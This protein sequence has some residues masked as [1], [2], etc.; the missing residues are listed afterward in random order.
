MPAEQSRILIYLLPALPGFHPTVTSA[1]RLSHFLQEEHSPSSPMLGARSCVHPHQEIHFNDSQ[2][3]LMQSVHFSRPSVLLVFADVGQGCLEWPRA[4]WGA[5]DE[6]QWATVA[7]WEPSVLLT[8][9]I[10]TDTKQPKGVR[11]SSEEAEPGCTCR[12]A[13]P[14]GHLSIYTPKPVAWPQCWPHALLGCYLVHVAQV[15]FSMTAGSVICF[16]SGTSWT[17]RL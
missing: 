17:W 12:F 10:T 13:R 4:V 16:P 14:W 1:F 5:W 8:A 6:W 3:S 2:N 15:I 9:L 11:W 7:L